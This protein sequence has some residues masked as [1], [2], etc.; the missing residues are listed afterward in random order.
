MTAKS[1]VALL[2]SALILSL[3]LVFASFFSIPRYDLVRM[4]ANFALRVDRWTGETLACIYF[5]NG[6]IGCNLVGEV[7]PWDQPASQA[8]QELKTK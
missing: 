6:Q 5:S 3:G 4:D 1:N 2:L 7:A 8:E